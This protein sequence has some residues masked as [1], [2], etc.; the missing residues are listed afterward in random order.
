MDYQSQIDNDSMVNTPPVYPVWVLSLVLEWLESL[1]GVAAVEKINRQK[2]ESLY[3]AIDASSFYRNPVAKDCRSWMNIP[4]V[5]SDDSLDSKFIDASQNAGLLNLKGHRSVGGMRA[6]IYNAITQT[7]VDTLIEF[8]R[9]FE[10]V[11]A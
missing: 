7:D 11:S 2:A 6:S 5:L 1:G 9:E 8:M 10:R 4:F 3:A